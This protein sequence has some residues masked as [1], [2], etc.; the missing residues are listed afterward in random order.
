MLLP[1]KIVFIPQR[2]NEEPWQGDFVDALDERF[3]LH[4][5]DADAPLAPQ[6]AGARVVVDQGGW[7]T[8]AMI[9]A[10]AE[11][12]VALWQ[13]I[14]MGL[15]HT[16]VDHI[17]GRGMRLANTP[18][19]FSAIA[20]GEHA[21]FLL[22]CFAKRFR[23]LE[24]NVRTGVLWHPLTDELP[25]QTLGIVGLG[26]SGRELALRA[27]A[28]GMRIVAVDP[29]DVSEDVLAE[30][31]VE[32]FGDTDRLDDLLRES[33]YVSLHVPL[34]SRT[35]HLIDREKLALMKPSAVLIN[36]ARGALVDEEALVDCLRE[37]RLR[38]AGLDVFSQE[39]LP[40]D[41]PFLAL[42]NVIATPHVAGVTRG[43]SRRRA[44]VAVEN[45][46][47]VDEGL[48]PLYEITSW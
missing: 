18:G 29:V 14:G 48:D 41:S 32:W 13:V 43:T 33:D 1:V 17:L 8:K 44:A 2:G 26:A 31:G 21:L 5:L 36:V 39:P 45:A 24:E 28:M 22:L 7:G 3:D 25:A 34:N 30:H 6:F 35:R 10:A 19:Q 46:A 16:E 40:A 37:G 4:I 20:L 38:G 9:E 15:D 12:G 23:E 47:R 11:A 27:K 42:E